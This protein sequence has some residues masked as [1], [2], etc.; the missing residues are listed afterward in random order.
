[1]SETFQPVEVLEGVTPENIPFDKLF[2]ADKPVILKGLVKTWPMV[3]QG[4]NNAL[5]VM[6]AL[7]QAYSGKPML[8][9]KGAPEIKARFG[10]NDACNGFN[11]VSERSTIP[12]V[13]AAIRAQL[14]KPSHHYL[15][16]NSLRLDDGFPSLVNSHTLH[17]DHPEFHQ[18]R[19]MAKIWL[20]TESIAAAHFDQPKN[21]ACCVLGKRRFL[22]FPPDQIANLYPGPLSPTPGGQVVTMADLNN[23]DFEKYPR[24]EEA[25]RHAQ[26]AEL[27]PGD[28]LYYPSMWWHEVQSYDRFNVMVNFWW[29]TAPAYMGSAMDALLHGMMSVR[30][31]PDSEKQAWRALFD[32]YVFGESDKVTAHLPEACQGA[33]A[34]MD[35]N[36]GRMM[37]AMLLKNLNR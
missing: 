26:V 9:Y 23:P 35:E 8:V 31:K 6:T 29:M 2:E 4:Q 15:Y 27:A 14:D 5:A 12:D 37:R 3:E 18:N 7:E 10:Y 17:F 36:Q 25:F 24:L 32:Y 19:P 33:L 16:I 13:F 28:G 20:G 11:F 21:L 34:P 22:L 1:M 30:D